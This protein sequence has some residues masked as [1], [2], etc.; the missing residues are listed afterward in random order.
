MEKFLTGFNILIVDDEKDIAETVADLI[1]MWGGTAH[2]AR[3]GNVALK[4]MKEQNLLV[5]LVLSDVRMADGNGVELLTALRAT[6]AEKPIVLMM[7]GWS[8]Y[9]REEFIK[10]GAFDL[11][12]KPF[13]IGAFRHLVIQALQG[14][15][16]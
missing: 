8:D 2:I 9:T 6:D 13:D 11:M 10:M 16:R 1:F 7:S 5:D 4:M 14:K 12:P 3:S 15:G